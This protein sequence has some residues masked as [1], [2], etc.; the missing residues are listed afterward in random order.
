MAIITDIGTIVKQAQ[1]NTVKNNMEIIH[2]VNFNSTQEPRLARFIE[3][4]G[5]KFDAIRLQNG[6]A[7]RLL[8]PESHPSWTSILKWVNQRS[9][10]D[11][12]DTIFSTQEILDAEWLRVTN[13][14]A[15]GYPQ[16]E[17]SWVTRPNNLVNFCHTCGTY[18]QT[19]P[20]HISK[21]PRMRKYKF[22]SLEWT[23]GIIFTFP[24]ILESISSS[25]IKGY[26]PWNAIIH[27]TKEP[28]KNI[29]QL[30]V[31]NTTHS[32]LV[33]QSEEQEFTC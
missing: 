22:M 12:C 13:I 18:E 20:F 6:S 30:F 28:A 26:E 14:P 15:F 21:E 5:L 2:Q 9:V 8:I 25:D 17:S 23:G 31:P 7:I 1:I 32:G 11:K 16:P 29:Y 33:D 4:S 3:E 27:K 10:R 24:E 19:T